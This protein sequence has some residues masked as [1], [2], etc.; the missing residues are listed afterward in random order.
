MLAHL[1][2]TLAHLASTLARLASTLAHLASTLAHIAIMLVRLA[3]ML[4]HLAS[5]LVHLASTLVRLAS[6]LRIFFIMLG[7][8]D[9]NAKRIILIKESCLSGITSLIEEIDMKIRKY[10]IP[11]TIRAFT[12]FVKNFCAKVVAHADEWNI[13][14]TDKNRTT[15]FLADFEDAQAI[16]D[17]P[18]TRTSVTVAVAKTAREALKKHIQYLRQVYIDPGFKSGVISEHD[19]LSLGLSLADD[20]VTTHPLTPTTIPF[21]V[22]LTS[23]PGHRVQIHFRDETSEK[24]EARPYGMNGCLARFAISDGKTEDTKLLI[25]TELM[26]RSPYT[27]VFTPEDEGKLLSIA[28]CWQNNS[29]KLG[30]LSAISHVVIS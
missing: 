23:P 5:T 29:G 14:T 15:A 26:T 27:L 25:R 6:T 12:E 28:A 8:L 11:E 21:I 9:K 4:A 20:V 22:G 18:E 24:S 7:I 19:Y 13:S 16:A 17:A 30:S 10:W 2:S 1:V 3:I